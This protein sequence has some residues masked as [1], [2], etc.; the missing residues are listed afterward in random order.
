MTNSTPSTDIATARASGPADPIGAD[1]HKIL[2][3]LKLGGLKDTLPERLALAR[4]RKIG[5]AAFLELVLA[6]EVARRE[7]RSAMLRARAAGLDP[8]MR[9][10]TWDE[11]ADLTYDRML[12]SDLTSLRFT[13]PGH[14]VLILGPVG[15]GKTHLATALGHI[16]IRRRLSV[17]AARTDKLFTRLRAARLDNSLEAEMRKLA[18]VDLLILDDFALRALDAN[19]TNDFYELI[20]ER[21]RKAATIVTSNREPSE[22]LPMMSDALLAQSAIDRLTSEAHTLIIEGPSYRQRHRPGQ[23]ATVDTESEAQ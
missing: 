19:Q 4:A 12:L 22:W 14:G 21:H 9:L 17:Y 7:S 18:R 11:P 16:A 23:H 3:A 20:V 8:T 10:D 6:D 2:R 15:V 13:G 1:L 5:H